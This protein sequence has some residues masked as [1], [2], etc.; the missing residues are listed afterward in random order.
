MAFILEEE[1]AMFTG[2]NVLGHGTAVFEDLATYMTSLER[3]RD[4]SSGR[5]YPG[6]GA[7]IEHGE[8]C[9]TEYIEHRQQRER[10]VLNVLEGAT[11][12][13]EQGDSPGSGARTPMEIVK[14]VYRDVPVNLHEPAAGGVVQILQKLAGEGKVVQVPDGHGWQVAET[15]SAM[16]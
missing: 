4:Q 3:M 9:I 6:H 1:D 10:E 14:I 12:A 8:K 11:K 2:D 15:S 16:M 5:G 7:V 13:A